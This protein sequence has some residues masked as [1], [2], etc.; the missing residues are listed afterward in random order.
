[1]V[2]RSNTLLVLDSSGSMAGSAGGGQ[3]KLEA[4]KEA[5]GRYVLG[6][7]DSAELGFEVYGHKGSN[8][9]ADKAESCRSAEVLQP[10]GK[11]ASREIAG[12][13]R[14]FRPAGYTP[15]GA[16][17]EEARSA[18]KGREGEENR[19]ILVS[20]GIETCGGD[21]LAA[22]DGLKRAGV[23][24]TVDVVGYDIGKESDRA[25]LRRIAEV[26]GG[27]YS[28]ARDGAALRR[29]FNEELARFRDLVGAQLCLV[30]NKSKVQLCQVNR[31]TRAYAFMNREATDAA[32]RGEDDEA[33][34]IRRLLVQVRERGQQERQET[35]GAADQRLSRIRRE[36]RAAGAR[37]RR[38]P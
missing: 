32:R 36:L 18:F 28:D 16:A 23:A 15:I 11:G 19:I 17:L 31:R 38:R 29:F 10:L 34:E 8:D 26:T 1:M 5:L 33:A 30:N 25:R 35:E 37:L 27:R 2:E 7:P 24:V 20:D 4:A 13:L 14:R 21:P 6:S 3:T 12:T 22:A 9:A